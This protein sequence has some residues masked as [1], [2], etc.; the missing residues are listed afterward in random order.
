[1]A[2]FEQREWIMQ[3][4]AGKEQ[5]SNRFDAIDGDRQL[6]QVLDTLENENSQLRT[7]VVRLSET[8]I[9]NATAKR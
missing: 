4:T 8:I 1:M 5:W 7:L 2:C 6:K 3:N 9:R